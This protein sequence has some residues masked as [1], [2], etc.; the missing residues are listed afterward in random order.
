MARVIAS[1]FRSAIARKIFLDRYAQKTFDASVLG[2]GST[3]VINPPDAKEKRGRREVAV[4]LE[5]NGNGVAKVKSEESGKEWDITVEHIDIPEE[6]TYEDTALRVGQAIGEGEHPETVEAM[7]KMLRDR[8]FVPSGRILTAAGSGMDLTCYNCLPPEQEILTE[9]GYR[10]IAD[11]AVGDRVVT[12]KGRLRRVMAFMSRK[13]D[14]PMLT[15]KALKMGFDDVRVTEDHKILVMKK[16]SINKHR[17]RDGIKLSEEPSWV[18]AGEI[19]VGDYMAVETDRLEVDIDQFDA[20][21]IIDDIDKS[22]AKYSMLSTININEKTCLLFGHWLGN[23]CVTHRSGTKIPSGIK[24]TYNLKDRDVAEEMAA[25]IEEQFGIP[26]SVKVS[27]NERWIDVWANS[28]QIGLFF[29]KVFGCYSYAKR[30][31]QWLMR[32]PSAKNNALIKGLFKTDG[33][34]RSDGGGVGILLAN[35]VLSTQLHMLLLRSGML[36]SIRENT[37]KNSRHPSYRLSASLGEI[38]GYEDIFGVSADEPGFS[39]FT[40]YYIEYDGLRWVRIK[41]IESDD[42]KGEVVDIEV[43]EDHSFITAGLVVSN[44][45]VIPSPHDSREGILETAARQFEIMSRGGGVGINVSSLRPK[46]DIVKGV[47]GRSSGAVEWADLFSFMTFKVEQAGS[48]R[49]ALMIILDVWHPEIM[50]FIKSKSALGFLDYANISVGLSQDFMDAVYKG[51]DW[52]LVFP[53]RDDPDYDEVWDGDLKKWIEDGRKVKK[54]KTL[55]AS[56][57]WDAICESAWATAEPGLFFVDRTNAMSNSWYYP[58]GRIRTTNPCV[59]GSTRLATDHGLIRVDDL[60]VSQSPINCTV[61]NRAL[62]KGLGTSIRSAVPVFMTSPS[63]EVFEVKT[64]AGYKITATAW[65]EFYTTRGK[66]ELKDL[67]V[68]DKLHVQSGKGQFGQEGSRDLGLVMG[69][70]AGDGHFTDAGKGRDKAVLGLWGEDRVYA[71]EVVESVNNL[72]SASGMKRVRKV[73]SIAIKE[74]DEERIES[75]KLAE[76]LA[77]YGFDRKTKHRVPE[78][79]WR[80]TEECAKGYLQGLFQADGTVNVSGKKASCSVRLASSQHEHLEDV[81]ILLANFGILGKVYKRREAQERYLPDGKGGLKAYHTKAQYELLI[82]NTSREV[83]FNEI[84]FFNGDRRDVK[85]REWVEGRPIHKNQRF[86]TKIISITPKGRV[87]VYD[88]TQD[89]HNAVIFNGL[90]TG[91]CGEQG[92]PGNAVCNLGALN[93]GMF[94]VPDGEGR[95]FWPTIDENASRGMIAERIDFERIRQVATHATRFLDNVI[96]KTHYFDDRNKE[97]QFSERRVGLGI[98]GLAELFVRTGITYGDE[99]SEIATDM[100]FSTIRDAA[101]SASIQLAKEKGPFPWFDRDKFMQSGYALT[102]PDEIQ[103]GIM[104]HGIRNVTLLTVAPTGTTGSMMA[105][106]T[107]I[108]PYFLFSFD[109]IGNLGR[110]RVDEPIVKEFKEA[111]ECEDGHDMPLPS[112]FVTTSDLQ[113]EDHVGI[114]AI[115]QKYV[116]ASISKTSNLPKHYTVDQVKLFYKRLY[117]LGCKGGTVYRDGSREEQC[118]EA[119]IEQSAEHPDLSGPEV[120]PLPDYPRAGFTHSG[121]TP[122]GAAHVTLTTDDANEPFDCFINLSKAGSESAAHIAAMGRLISYNLRLRSDVPRSTRM[123][124]MIEQLEGIAS[125][126]VQGFG[127]KKVLSVP[128]GIAKVLRKLTAAIETQGVIDRSGER[129]EVVKDLTDRPSSRYTLSCPE[130]GNNTAVKADGCFKCMVCDFSQC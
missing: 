31:P 1:G 112:H 21:S 29:K 103:A 55:K 32:L 24:I 78:I 86:V 8:E 56:D 77:A 129:S 11:V 110:N 41:S 62:S 119:P 52:D 30:I 26:S 70:I 73:G 44:C 17:S 57:I 101:Y 122:L 120:E 39:R 107:G 100:I 92:L 35:R 33:Y 2:P 117:E 116:D 128:D 51:E 111:M 105:T 72:L 106:S 61:D 118:L 80:G 60:H 76:L 126:Q 18:P 14:E 94:T 74:R 20:T 16:D 84:G 43:E 88:T 83:F 99:V 42:Y 93:L 5:Y 121:P 7:V 3:V 109:Q 34:V 37:H 82:D 96:D 127:D 27:S 48:R 64:K 9:D 113:P 4:V 102:L 40:T 79:V 67:K 71:A 125:M 95:L 12:H 19:R 45:Y 81:Q 65:H 47:N 13:A 15:I 108:E 50:D 6:L 28:K 59:I 87:P 66:I 23:G 97:Q 89:D 36:F 25:I 123:R 75:V 130:C 53:D 69:L 115:A 38:R 114:Q 124:H 22:R 91:Q 46:R 54:Y 90:S 85:Y 58:Q 68:G 63:E 98:M 49:G 104:E 10:P